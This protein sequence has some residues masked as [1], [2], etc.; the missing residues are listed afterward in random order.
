MNTQPIKTFIVLGN[1][2]ITFLLIDSERTWAIYTKFIKFHV[3]FMIE[4]I[5]A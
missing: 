1:S 2:K 3:Y 5:K 4:A